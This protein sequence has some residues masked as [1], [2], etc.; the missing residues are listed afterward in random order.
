VSV[1]TASAS[2]GNS[3]S[4]SWSIFSCS[5]SISSSVFAEEGSG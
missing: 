4:R 5:N 2:L 3:R 1:L